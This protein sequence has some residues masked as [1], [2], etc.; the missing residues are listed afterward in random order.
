M[1]TGIG[2]EYNGLGAAREGT[3]PMV[4]LPSIRIARWR[5]RDWVLDLAAAGLAFAL[6]GLAL[7]RPGLSRWQVTLTL[8]LLAGVF[9]ING[10]KAVKTRRA[11]LAREPSRV[12]RELAG[13]TQGVHGTLCV[14][15][16]CKPSDLG[17]RAA[18]LKVHWDARREAPVDLE[19]ITSYYGGEGGPA[20]RRIS[21]RTGIVGRVARSG[22]PVRSK[23]VSA[24]VDAFRAE[25]VAVWSFTRPEAARISVDRWAWF[26][27]PLM[28]DDGRPYGAV[29]LDA[30]AERLFDNAE[31][32]EAVVGQCLV[33]SAIC[34]ST[35]GK[36][37]PEPV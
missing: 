18:I 16:A 25:L 4:E 7:F 37:P 19:Q 2:R 13:W 31:T 30:K 8:C 21:A 22:R 17:V 3:G 9:T 33:L 15:P 20:G 1:R 36:H 12:P 35:Y 6:A 27:V 5:L 26:A 10:R 28:P 34:Q 32:R 24:D 23:R 11:E 14:L 29:Y